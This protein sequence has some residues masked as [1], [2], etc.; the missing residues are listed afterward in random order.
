MP[1]IDQ[2]STFTH[3]FGF[4]ISIVSIVLIGYLDYILDPAY[5]LPAL[6]VIPTIITMWYINIR[7]SIIISIVSAI[8]Q[9]I[10]NYFDADY[11]STAY[12]CYTF[13]TIRFLVLVILISCAMRFKYALMQERLL[14]RMD[15][16]CD[17]LNSRAFSEIITIELERY[18]RH[19]HPL[20]IVYIDI[21]NFK[22]INDLYGHSIGDNLLKI[23]S[24]VLKNNVRTIDTVARLGGDEFSILLPET[25]ADA[26]HQLMIRIQ[27][28]LLEK[29][30]QQQWSVTFSIGIVTCTD[31]SP[32]TADA[33]IRLADEQMYRVKRHGKNNI[34]LTVYSG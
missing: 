2:R 17:I 5:S 30:R 9:G 22:T 28:T 33:L 18:R 25:S 24:T 23:F 12:A 13:V 20:S 8:T 3:I 21:D 6:Y 27:S 14:S 31:S 34:Q 26:T 4:I 7:L 32:L 16:L 19:R 1:S 10:N 15:Q 29:M 11:F